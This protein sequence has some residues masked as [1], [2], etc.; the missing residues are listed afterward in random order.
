MNFPTQPWNSLVSGKVNGIT[1]SEV[2]QGDYSSTSMEQLCF[3]PSNEL[4]HGPELCNGRR[5]ACSV[6]WNH[7]ANT[8]RGIFIGNCPCLPRVDCLLNKWKIPLRSPRGMQISFIFWFFCRGKFLRL[9]FSFFQLSGQG[10]LTFEFF[11]NVNLL[12]SVIW[13]YIST[14]LRAY[15][16]FRICHCLKKVEDCKRWSNVEW[17]TLNLG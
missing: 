15:L 2:N 10:I 14:L 13:R 7:S 1:L 12:E 6:W 16:L 17:W 5:V 11:I 9:R 8:P 3:R 4:R